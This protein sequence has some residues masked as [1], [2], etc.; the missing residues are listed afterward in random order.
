MNPPKM[1]KIVDNLA[2]GEWENVCI[3]VYFGQPSIGSAQSAA[4][5]YRSMGERHPDGL[6]SVVVVQEGVPLPDPDVRRTVSEV[7]KEVAPSIRA[8][9]GVYESSG[10]IGAA[11][12]SVITAMTL[13]SKASYRTNT[14]SNVRDAAAWI[15]PFVRPARTVAQAEVALQQ[16][17]KQVAEHRMTNRPSAT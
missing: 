10:F 3:F 2:M 7:M 17:R 4:E 8:M 14:V 6:V 5:G 12:R 15:A 16:F 13:M 9:C 1:T 11:M